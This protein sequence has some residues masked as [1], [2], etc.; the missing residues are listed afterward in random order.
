MYQSERLERILEC[1]HR[2][3]YVTVKALTEELDYSTA[4]VNR[5]LNLLE[6]RNLVRRS[7]GGVTLAEERV[8]PLVARYRQM[9]KTK[10]R[11]SEI[12]VSLLD[13]GDVIFVDGSSTTEALGKSL[14]EPI[15]ARKGITVITNNVALFLYLTEHGG[16]AVLLG[17]RMIEPPYVLGGRETEA[18][19]MRYRA[20]KAFFSAAAITEDGFIS[21]DEEYEILRRIMVANAKESYFLCDREKVGRAV[22]RVLFD[23]SEV[24]GIISDY[25]FSSEVRERYAGT[26]F[27]GR[28]EA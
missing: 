9:E 1:L 5:D 23:A 17:G 25:P 13:E 16:S 11:L 3:G 26:V 2:K 18:N 12:A 27:L 28:E 7:Y 22:P 6:A 19:A 15:T 20:D 10:D 8:P 14:C 4:T 24:T 21:A